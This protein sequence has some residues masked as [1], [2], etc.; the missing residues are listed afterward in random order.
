MA[1]LLLIAFPIPWK[2]HVVQVAS[3]S[4]RKEE[5]E[6]WTGSTDGRISSYLVVIRGEFRPK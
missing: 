6:L 4:D 2:W 5:E 1:R 3:L